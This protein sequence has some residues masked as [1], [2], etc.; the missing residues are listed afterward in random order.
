M[1]VAD[2]S[3]VAVSGALDQ[4]ASGT[5]TGLVITSATFSSPTVTLTTASNPIT[6][7][8][9]NGQ[10]IGIYCPGTCT[11]GMHN[12]SNFTVGT[13]TSTQITYSDASGAACASSCGNIGIQTLSTGTTA[14]TAQANELVLA[15]S[16]YQPQQPGNNTSTTSGTPTPASAVELTDPAPGEAASVNLFPLEGYQV[17]TATG[18]QNETWNLQNA[19][20]EY[21][22]VVATFLQTTPTKGALAALNTYPNNLAGLSLTSNSHDYALAPSTTDSSIC[23]GTC[24]Y[25]TNPIVLPSAGNTG[26]GGL[27]QGIHADPEPASGMVGFEWTAVAQ[28]DNSQNN[29]PYIVPKNNFLLKHPTCGS[30]C[31][32]YDVVSPVSQE[33]TIAA[34]GTARMVLQ[35]MGVA[36]GGPSIPT[37]LGTIELAFSNGSTATAAVQL[38]GMA[39]TIPVRY[40]LNP[41]DMI[42]G[43]NSFGVAGIIE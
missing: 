38:T 17:V 5:V 30:G 24:I 10:T 19:A 8:F 37:V 13:V 40:A 41:Y 6:A 31:T 36:I 29:I 22:G 32:I 39:I 27:N 18:T 42:A 16:G 14:A 2:Y 20:S 9:A 15:V 12:G 35:G 21:A 23:A 3:N 4:T 7:G 28:I 25:A 11:G 34:G 1:N 26:S 43:S 33:V